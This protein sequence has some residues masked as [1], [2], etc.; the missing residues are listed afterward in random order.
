MKNKLVSYLVPALLLASTALAEGEPKKEI[1]IR[2]RAESGPSGP[3]G[4]GGTFNVE[5]NRGASA[6]P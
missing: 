2:R 4:P 6:T 1:V 5:I 3:G